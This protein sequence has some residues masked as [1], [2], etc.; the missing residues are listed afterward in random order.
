MKPV[1][2][3]VTCVTSC[4]YGTLFFILWCVVNPM[5]IVVNKQDTWKGFPQG[6]LKV[7]PF[8]TGCT[9]NLR[10][11]HGFKDLFLYVYCYNLHYFDQQYVV[12]QHRFRNIK[13]EVFIIK[14]SM[15]TYITVCVIL[16][17]RYRFT[18]NFYCIILIRES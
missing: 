14:H 10:Y 6:Y 16:I 9:L 5:C 12:F 3:Y 2:T 4:T 1:Y 8:A 17:I 11:K 13:I 18:S 7:L 15:N